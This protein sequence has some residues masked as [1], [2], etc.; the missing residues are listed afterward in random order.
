MSSKYGRIWKKTVLTYFK[1]KFAM[2][3]SK[4]LLLLVTTGLS[5]TLLIRQPQE[6]VY[7]IYG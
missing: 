6:N 5:L 7:T 1:V 4:L 3:V 2:R